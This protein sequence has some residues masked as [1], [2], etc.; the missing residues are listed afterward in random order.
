VTIEWLGAVACGNDGTGW[1]AAWQA[2]ECEILALTNQRRAAGAVCGGK[3]MPPVGPLA[4]Q[5]QL[6]NSARLHAKDMG[7]RN[8][9]D[10]YT[11]EGKSPFDR[12]QAA[13]FSGSS[14]GENISAGQSSARQAMED[15]MNSPHHCENIMNA[16]FKYLGV[17]Y[18]AVPTGK[19][20]HLWVQNFG[21]GGGGGGTVPYQPPMPAPSP[22]PAPTPTSAPPVTPAC[23]TVEQVFAAAPCFYV[24]N[25]TERYEG[26]EELLR[27][28]DPN[29]V[30]QFCLQARQEGYFAQPL[31][32]LDIVPPPPACLTPDQRRVIQSCIENGTRS[33]DR[34]A[35][36]L[37][38]F[39]LKAP[40]RLQRWVEAH[41]CELAPLPP[42]PAQP[43]SPVKRS[44][45][46]LPVIVGAAII[47]GVAWLLYA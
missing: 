28:L 18:Y 13:G 38:W 23:L 15:W 24:N 35:N 25:T 29:K 3:K 16:S 36:W 46:V 11:P 40:N 44:R 21:G 26:P 37:C 17:G 12:M 32:D 42:S 8:Y 9:F 30:A 27:G 47:G 39:G 10:H 1:K 7:D 43:L 5:Q 19:Y 31:C 20:R 45:S 34:T 4:R 6:T 14:M 2:F 33:S 41:D 22:T